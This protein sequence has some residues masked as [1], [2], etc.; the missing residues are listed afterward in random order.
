MSLV[1]KLDPRGLAG[2]HR[3]RLGDPLERL[4]AGHLVHGDRVRILLEIQG[5]GLQVGL[6]NGLDLLL[7]TSGS[8]SLVLSQYLLRCGCNAAWAR[9]AADLADR[10]GLHDSASDDFL[11][12]F[13]MCPAIDGPPRL[14]GRFAG[15]GQDERHLLGGEC[16]GRTT[17]RASL[18]TSSMARRKFGLR[19]ATFDGNVKASKRLLP[20]P[21][22]EADLLSRQGDFGSDVHIEQSGEG[23]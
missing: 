3:D 4:N 22:P 7:E 10:N 17:A 2:L 23:Q 16:S 14:L 19:L 9:V 13:A 11:G 21:P 6:A 15:H 12:Q 18:R 20:P 1:F 8:F 5:R